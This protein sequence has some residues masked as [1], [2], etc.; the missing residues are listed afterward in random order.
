MFMFIILNMQSM[1]LNFCVSHLLKI[2][3][4]LPWGKMGHMSFLFISYFSLYFDA[5]NILALYGL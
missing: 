5:L 2:C 3:K 4:K 1:N